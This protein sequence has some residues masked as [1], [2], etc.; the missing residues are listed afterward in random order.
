MSHTS[1]A[2]SLVL[3]Q[4]DRT[5]LSL[6]A[7]GYRPQSIGQRLGLTRPAVEAILQA[8]R[9]RNGMANNVQLAVHMVRSAPSLSH[10]E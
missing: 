8:A 4:R 7:E 1:H 6:M 9:R 3:T 10:P 2:R 5:I